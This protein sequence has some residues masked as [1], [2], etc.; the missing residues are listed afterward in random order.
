M[1]LALQHFPEGAE[2]HLNHPSH[3]KPGIAPIA[4][5]LHVVTMM[6]NP[7][8]W[9]SRYTNYWKFQKHVEDS[10]AILHTVEVAFGDRKHEVTERGNP[11]HTQL[12]TT[13]EVWHKE[14]AMNI[15]ISRL[16]AEAK[17]IATI[18]SDM[19]FART[20]WAQE[21]MHLLQHYPVIQMYSH[22]KDV[23]PEAQPVSDYTAVSFVHLRNKQ[24]EQDYPKQE[25]RGWGCPGGAWAYTR[26]ALNGIGGLMDW[27][28]VGSGDYYMAKALYGELAD[29]LNLANY[30]P[31]YKE[32]AFAWEENAV[33]HIK[34][35][36]G[37]MPGLMLHY[38]HGPKSKRGYELRPQFLVNSKF[39]P[40]TDIKKDS[41]GLFV[42]TEHNPGLRDWLRN[43]ARLRNEDE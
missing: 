3:A 13:D 11:N 34:R 17:Y 4:D 1:K 15:G 7:L 39:N 41:Q 42:L 40:V 12:K 2:Q 10:G 27:V 43:T 36:V 16:P 19:T 23:G 21:T 33:R 31:A 8:R 32:L 5:R 38:W 6:S 28:I 24:N 35:S 29:I 25:Q 22:L 20:D 18:D 37:V 26:E 30:H 9:R 14:N